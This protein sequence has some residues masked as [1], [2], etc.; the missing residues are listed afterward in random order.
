MAIY[1]VHTTFT[2]GW[3]YEVEANS[4]R[5]A[6]EKFNEAEYQDE[7]MDTDWCGDSQETVDT[8]ELKTK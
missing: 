2:G 3:V 7:Y 4:A 8:V 1:K 5:E 6:E